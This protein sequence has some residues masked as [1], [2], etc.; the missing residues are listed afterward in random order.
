MFGMSFANYR[1][2]FNGAAVAVMR[3]WVQK[4]QGWVVLCGP[5][6]RGK[7]HLLAAAANQL[8]DLGQRPLYVMAPDLLD[9]LREGVAAGEYSRG[10]GRVPYSEVWGS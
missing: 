8:L 5:P 6:G 1:G 2:K 4:R 9:H 3:E 10:A 7:T